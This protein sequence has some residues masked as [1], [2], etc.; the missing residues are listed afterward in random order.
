MVK[1]LI[2]F[3]PALLA[4]CAVGA[5]ALSIGVSYI[6]EHAFEQPEYL[7]M[8]LDIELRKLEMLLAMAGI[9]LFWPAAVAY[10]IK[11]NIDAQRQP[12]ARY[13]MR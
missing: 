1:Q 9:V 13:S 8:V 4:Y 5:I 7:R 12:H 6:R 2:I 3:L 10:A 11:Q